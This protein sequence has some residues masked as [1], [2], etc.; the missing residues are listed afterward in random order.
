MG[1]DGKSGNGDQVMK[2][3]GWAVVDKRSGLI[4]LATMSNGT[5]GSLSVFEERSQARKTKANCPAPLA[6]TVRPVEIIVK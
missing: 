2:I 4:G 5:T 1:C 6:W 3:K